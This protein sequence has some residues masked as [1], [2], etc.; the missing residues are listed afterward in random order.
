M[1]KTNAE[2]TAVATN[3]TTAA[4]SDGTKLNSV[5]IAAK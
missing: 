2:V 4:V 3:Q 5:E 1:A